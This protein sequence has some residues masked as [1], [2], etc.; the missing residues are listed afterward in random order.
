MEIVYNDDDLKTYVAK[1]TIISGE[2]PILID[3]FLEDAYEFDVDALCDGEDV[4]IMRNGF[5]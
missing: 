5:V 4:F 2:H 1:A 3:K